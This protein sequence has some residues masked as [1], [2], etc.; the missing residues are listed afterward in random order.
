MKKR[1]SIILVL[2]SFFIIL[3]FGFNQIGRSIDVKPIQSIENNHQYSSSNDQNKNFK[4][5]TKI[6]NNSVP[7]QKDWKEKFEKQLK[8]KYNVTPCQYKSIG[9]GYW[10]VWV[11]E[12]DTGNDPYVTVNQKNGEFHG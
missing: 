5:A 3:I 9:N 2:F 12:I 4:Y 7:S 11:K 1:I 10:N 8:E 6:S